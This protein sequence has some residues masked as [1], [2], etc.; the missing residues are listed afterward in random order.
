MLV[1][2]EHERKAELPM[3]V[4]LLSVGIILFLHPMTKTLLAVSIKQFPL[5]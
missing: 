3:L 4:T 1:S 2:P 5:L